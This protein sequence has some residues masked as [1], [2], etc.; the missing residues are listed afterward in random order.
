MAKKAQK[1]EAPARAGCYIRVS[2]ENQ[3]ENYSIEEQTQ[4]LLAYCTARD[5]A[6]HSFYIDPGS[7]GGNLNRPA[8][9]R[10]LYDIYE[11]NINR[12]IVYKLDRLSRSQKDTL[13]L[14]EDEFFKN[15]VDFISVCENFDTSTPMGRAMIGILSVFAQLEKDQITERFTMGRVGRS[16]AGYYHGGP[17]P[18]TGYRY[19]KGE[20]IADEKTAPQVREAFSLFLS[21]YSLHAV[22]KTLHEKYGGWSGHALTARV[23]KNPVYI[24]KVRF[25]GQEYEGRHHPLI[26]ANTFYEAQ[27]LL[28]SPNREGAK[29]PSQRRPFRAASLL[30]G[31]LF[32]AR[33]GARYSAVHGFYRCY[34]RSKCAPRLIQDPACQNINWP[35]DQLDAIIKKELEKLV[36][37]KPTST[38]FCVYPQ[39]EKALLQREAARLTEG[40]EKLTQSL[41]EEGTPPSPES[42]ARLKAMTAGRD[43]LLFG[44]SQ[45]RRPH[46]LKNSPPS[47]KQLFGSSPLPEQ[48]L[49]LSCL[50]HSI[51]L[52]GEK[53]E[54]NW[55]L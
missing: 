3:L 50:I 16:R 20:L 13:L 55:R 48:R 36:F 34:S 45:S 51:R 43:A 54:I 27:T 30:S 46:H 29:T 47:F 38:P 32:C 42:A 8:L 52:D 23:L 6:I 14:I 24:G 5:I 41:K 12:V 15:G 17:T 49:F 25:G 19:I 28:S 33:C 18:P 7:S 44:L 21:G 2:T 22:T 39:E 10:L 26:D 35:I 9:N 4:R 1:G 53:I 31:L 40:I 37:E 11:K